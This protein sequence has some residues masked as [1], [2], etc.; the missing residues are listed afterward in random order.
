MSSTT[1]LTTTRH[2]TSIDKSHYASKQPQ[3]SQ[4][5]IV[6]ILRYI[7]TLPIDAKTRRLT[8]GRGTLGHTLF[9]DCSINRSAVQLLIEL[10]DSIPE[11][12]RHHE[13]ARNWS[14]DNGVGLAQ[15]I[16]SC[17]LVWINPY[18]SGDK[19]NRK[20]IDNSQSKTMR[21]SVDERLVVCN[22]MQSMRFPS[23][24][25][26]WQFAIRMLALKS[27]DIIDAFVASVHR[28]LH[29]GRI[30]FELCVYCMSDRMLRT[31]FDPDH[32][33]MHTIMIGAL[34]ASCVEAF[35][36]E[37]NDEF[38]RRCRTLLIEAESIADSR[39][40]W[41]CAMREY[42]HREPDGAVPSFQEYV[43]NVRALMHDLRAEPPIDD[44]VHVGWAFAALKRVGK[45]YYIERSCAYDNL[46]ELIWTVLAQRPELKGRVMRMIE[47]DFNDPDGECEHVYKRKRLP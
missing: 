6:D 27:T 24:D 20:K 32:I 47:R 19:R 46:H 41:M 22:L 12:I 14:V 10:V 34:T 15:L 13:H 16:V 8:I 40:R 23:R 42:A 3:L 28:H 11:F 45:R 39:Q 5:S 29:D 7:V 4:S 2:S 25:K 30:C 43:S 33:L 1:S 35:A 9:A 31:H 18:A 17:F 21:L 36:N 38:R 26:T 37:R 44:R